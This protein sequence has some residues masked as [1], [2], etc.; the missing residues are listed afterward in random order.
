MQKLFAEDTNHCKLYT[1]YMQRT[2]F[3]TNGKSIL[4]R[5][6]LFLPKTVL[7]KQ[8]IF[9]KILQII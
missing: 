3:R 9:L 6:L 1:Q 4:L 5:L 8:N 7:I 2:F